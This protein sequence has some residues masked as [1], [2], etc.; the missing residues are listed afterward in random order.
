M[1]PGVNIHTSDLSY[2]GLPFYMYVAGTSFAAPHTAGVMALLAGAFP[3]ASVAELEAA[4]RGSAQDLGATG[5]DNSYGHGL[6][7]A[8]A[9]Y[10]I[11]GGGANTPPQITS[12]PVTSATQ[13]VLY[14]YDVEASDAEGDAL[15]Y[16]LT[17]APAGMTIDPASGLISWTPSATQ[18]GNSAVTV[19]VT[20]AHGLQA[21]QSFTVSVAN[22][23]DA[24]VAGN[25]SYQMWQG[26]TLNVTA[27]G[28]LGNDSD[29][30]GDP[31]AAQLE[32]A[33][34]S[35]VLGLNA[36]GGFTYTPAAAFAGTTSFTYRAR[37]PAGALS[38]VATVALTVF[39]NQPPTAVNDSY[40][41]QQGV[42]LNV[43]APGV[44][45][46]DSDVD[47]GALTAQLE[48]A[49]ASGVLGLNANGG[50]TYTPAAG[51]AGTTNFTYRTKDPAG[52]LSGAATVT[53]TVGLPQADLAITQNSDGLTAV[54]RGTTGVTYT[55]V[56]T[57]NGPNAVTNAALTDTLPGS[58]R[59]TVNSWACT[60]PG[61]TCSA[62]GTGNTT[63]TGSVSLQNGGA[64]TY[65]LVGGIP[66]SAPLGNSTNRVTI[67]APSGVTDPNSSNNSA[68]DTDTITAPPADLA[69]TQNSDGRTSVVRGTTGVTYTIVVTNNG[70]SAVTGATL[71]DTLP[72][73]TRFTV[74]SW[75]CTAPG[76]T[77]SATGTGNTT[78]T[79]SVS[80]AVGGSATYTLVGSI[81]TA[82]PLGNST[83]SVTIAWSNDPTANNT[84]ADTDTIVTAA[85][86]F[87]SESGVA[88]LNNAGTTLSFGNQSGN[89][90]DTVTLTIGGTGPV[91]FGTATVSNGGTNI[92]FSKGVTDSCSG[93]AF[94]VGQTCQ[95]QINFNA[96]TTTSSRTGTLI[97][98]YTGP[99]G[100]PSPAQLNLTGS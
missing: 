64:A 87:T 80:L 24:P 38:G 58:T 15:T 46:N 34:A 11:L 73:S 29:I 53:L 8:L 68:S 48:S 40:T 41:V 44:L 4:L 13:G 97:V 96:P 14:Q 74:N 59:F 69:V 25:D 27:P 76:G 75:T 22:V 65:T 20:D 78:R 23:N 70:P 36:N 55:I 99:A 51:F 84:L 39:A 66:A 60:A 50:F 83:S 92:N 10:Q 79:G 62:T 91:T 17:Q 54:E 19:R 90:S 71:T 7:N 94:S 63:R 31:L 26:T 56:V 52:A 30:D 43:A 100:S 88:S 93:H 2:G 21:N 61:G 32:S 3:D 98:P 1:A 77:C 72:G 12:V 95:I 5:A 82:A 33:P 16:S 81:P 6:V 28:V 37:D 57:N 18:V 9:A 89:V 49:P 45:G 42:T 47:G 85:V 67:A 86:A 35:G